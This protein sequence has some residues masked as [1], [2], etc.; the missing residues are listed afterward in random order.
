MGQFLQEIMEQPQAFERL[1]GNYVEK[2][3]E[4]LIRT[5]YEFA[6]GVRNVIFTGMG[7][8]YFA[9]HVAANFLN[10]NGIAALLVRLGNCCITTSGESGTM[11]CL[12]QFL[13][14]AKLSK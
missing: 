11:I 8:S 4:G 13:N 6:K 14:Q 10:E 2:E 12:S 3:H 9:A 1:L 7:S 5:K